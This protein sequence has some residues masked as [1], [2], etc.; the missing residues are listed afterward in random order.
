MA[1]P[2][3]MD[4]LEAEYGRY[5]QP[6]GLLP[7]AVRDLL[8]LIDHARDLKR[9]RDEARTEAALRYLTTADRTPFGEPLRWCARNLDPDAVRKLLPP[10]WELVEIIPATEG[11]P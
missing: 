8:R 7:A 6:R 5:R 1:A 2:D 11:T 3:L 10:G 9:Q 4:V